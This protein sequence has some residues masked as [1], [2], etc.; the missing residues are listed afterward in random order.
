MHGYRKSTLVALSLLVGV[1]LLVCSIVVRRLIPDEY[2]GAQRAYFSA[3]EMQLAEFDTLKTG[4]RIAFIGSSPVIMGLSAEQIETATGAP[5]RNLAMNASRSVF[6]DYA[7]MVI[8]HIKPG[9]VVVIVNPNLRR[10]PQMQLPLTCVKHFGFECIRMQKGFQPHIIQD[11]LVLFT[12]RSFGDEVLRRTPRGDFIFP[13]QPQFT[14]FRPKFNG[15]FPTNG[16]DDMAK[17]AKDV[18]RH[19][20]CPIFVLT[21]LLPESEEIALWQDEFDKLWRQIDEAGLHDIVVEDSPLWNDRTL[22]DHDEHMSERGREI[23]SRSIIA[24]L[25]KNGLPGS[26]DRIEAR[27]N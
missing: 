17:L 16:A 13:E 26:C 22:F 19:G 2:I 24:K 18:R 23:W 6:Q 7:A 1:A 9:D 8:E 21:P 15:P 14:K 12:D 10:L 25:Q 11:S 20:G 5:T 4:Q 3:L 27:S